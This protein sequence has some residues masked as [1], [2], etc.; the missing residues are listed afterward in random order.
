M[1]ISEVDLE[2]HFSLLLPRSALHCFR[3]MLRSPGTISRSGI[4][5][6]FPCG[7]L[8]VV[9]PVDLNLPTANAVGGDK[10]VGFALVSIFEL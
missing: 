7:G 10:P 9:I 1:K 8:S 6:L 5:W 4:L 3:S 2:L